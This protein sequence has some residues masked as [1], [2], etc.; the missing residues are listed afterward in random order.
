MKLR[1]GWPSKPNIRLIA[2]G[3]STKLS[4]SFLEVMQAEALGDD[5]KDLEVVSL[6]DSSASSLT[7]R[8]LLVDKDKLYAAY[9]QAIAIHYNFLYIDLLAKD[10]NHMFYSG[11]SKRFVM[12]DTQGGE[13]DT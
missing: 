5:A 4:F 12:E 2:S 3:A 7:A 9:K 10:T 13:D 11:F 6:P 1:G 8:H